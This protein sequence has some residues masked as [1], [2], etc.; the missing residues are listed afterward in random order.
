MYPYEWEQRIRTATPVRMILDAGERIWLFGVPCPWCDNMI[1]SPFR[2]TETWE[3]PHL[4]VRRF[5]EC[6]TCRRRV[7][8]GTG[9]TD[10]EAPSVCMDEPDSSE[11]WLLRLAEEIECETKTSP[12]RLRRKPKPPTLRLKRKRQ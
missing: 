8:V 5:V 11:E 3:L 6:D 10:I 12:L 9:W 1:K 7:R 4:I 2:G